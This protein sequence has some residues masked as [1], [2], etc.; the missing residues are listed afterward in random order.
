MYPFVVVAGVMALYFMVA[1]FRRP[2]PAAILASVLWA[3]YAVYETYVANGTLCGANCNIRVDLLLFLPLLGIATYLALRQ[4]SS[5]R[6]VA[7][8]CLVCFGIAAWL[9]A[10]FGY[11]VVAVIAA[12]ATVIAAVYGVKS[13]TS[14]DQA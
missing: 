5:N 14:G 8:L 4:Q 10:I 3:A 13:G 9:A 6:A 2:R 12:V 7:I 11:T 1:A